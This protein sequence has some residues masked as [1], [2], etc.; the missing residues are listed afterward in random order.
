MK[1]NLIYGLRDPRNDVYMYIGKTT[2]GESRPL[3]HLI[4]SHNHLVNEWVKELSDLSL[5]PF[6]DVIERDIPLNDLSERERYY[7]RY[8]STHHESLL[9]GG[10]HTAE[11]ISSPPEFSDDDI[12]KAIQVLLNLEEVFKKIKISTGYS[13]DYISEFIGVGRKTV[14]N[15]KKNELSVMLE[16]V[17]KFM[18]LA[19]HDIEELF[20]YYYSN[21]HEFKGSFPDTLDEFKTRCFEDSKF[22]ATWFNKFFNNECK[23]NRIHY[24]KRSPKKSKV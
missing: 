4:K 6:I 16:T 21:S 10:S 23:V 11:C 8:Y 24:N 20:E 13:S 18:F 2:V 7:I 19:N 15:I 3:Q 22:A 1:T 17:I 9:N 14:Y 12:E 5:S